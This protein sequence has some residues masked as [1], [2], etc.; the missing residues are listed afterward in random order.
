MKSKRGVTYDD[1]F[2]V[3]PVKANSYFDPNEIHVLLLRHQEKVK[4]AKENKQPLPH[5]CHILKLCFWKVAEGVLRSPSFYKWERKNP[6]L[7]EA[8][9]MEGY[10]DLC[11][12]AHYY[13]PNYEARQIRVYYF[14]LLLLKQKYMKSIGQYLR[15]YPGTRL[16]DN[17]FIEILYGDKIQAKSSR[18][19]GNNSIFDEGDFSDWSN[20]GLSESELEDLMNEDLDNMENESLEGNYIPDKLDVEVIE[21]EY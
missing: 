2:K 14:F 12:K 21:E 11:K 16:S 5:P 20:M 1:R 9:H 15:R 10:E 6:D 8:L 7:F 17:D 19:V 3:I 18:K 13:K 4:E